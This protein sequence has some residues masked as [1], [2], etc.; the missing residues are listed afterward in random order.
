M[1]VVQESSRRFAYIPVDS[2]L[3]KICVIAKCAAGLE[4]DI[5]KLGHLYRANRAAD[6]AAFLSTIAGDVAAWSTMAGNAAA[7]SAAMAVGGIS[8]IF[9]QL[10]RPNWR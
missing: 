7:A 3:M 4:P 10:V 2:S 5:T 8:S 1:S 9:E 6:S